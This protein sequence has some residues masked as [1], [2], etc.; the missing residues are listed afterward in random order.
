MLESAGTV[1]IRLS[2]AIAIAGMSVNRLRVTTVLQ[3]LPYLVP[4]ERSTTILPTSWAK[5]L[6]VP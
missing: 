6:F 5:Q 2:E 4:N 1:T 3:L